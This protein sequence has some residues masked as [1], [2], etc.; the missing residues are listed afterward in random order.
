MGMAGARFVRADLHVHLVPDGSTSPNQPAAAYINAAVAQNIEV[1]GITDHN[2]ITF[3]R[4]ALNAAVGQP[5]LVL[6]G[7]EV[8]SRDGHLL[9]LFP[10][11]GLDEL[12]GFASPT[13]L[14]LGKPLADGSRR[15]S[16]TMLHLLNEVEA[17]HG[18][19]IIAHCDTGAGV[20]AE[21]KAG[22]LAELL[23]HPALAGVEFIDLGNLQSWFA[24]AD[25][26]P[27]RLAAWK[28]RQA[29][30]EL[31]ERG[32]ARVM[33]SDAHDASL[34]GKDG[35]RRPLT[36]LRV[37][38]RTYTA[39]RNALLYNPKS[40]VRLEASLPASYPHLTSATFEGGFL[41][42]VTIDLVQNLNCLIGGRGSGKSTAL[43]A[44]L[45]ALG[46]DLAADV[47]PDDP[48]RM[49]DRTIVR[50]VDAAGTERQAIRERGYAPTDADGY[51]VELKLADLSQGESGQVAL[52]YR[53]QRTQILAYLDSFCDLA[54]QLDAER[55]VLERLS[56]N[57]ADVQRTAFRAAD[58]KAAEAE[59]AKLDANIM[60]AEKGQLE[61]IAKWARR[62][63]GQ[64]ALIAQVRANLERLGS[65]R[66]TAAMP[67]LDAL[68][69]ETQADLDQ[70][71]IKDLRTPLDQAISELNLAL[72]SADGAHATSIKVAT[73][74]VTAVIAQ[75][76]LEYQRWESKRAKV[77]KDLED[78]GLSVQVGAIQ[79]MG[80]RLGALTKQLAEMEERRK[81]HAAALKARQGLLNDLRECRRLIY[82]RRRATLRK[83]TAM[84][85]DS[86]LDLKVDVSYVHEGV[87]RPWREWLQAR[88]GF[89]ADRLSRLGRTIRPWEFAEAVA[90]GDLSPI[91]KIKDTDGDGRP[92]FTSDD[93]ER[94]ADLSWEERFEIET[95]RLE[96]LPRVDVTE[97]SL[98][99]GFDHLSTG[100]Q[101]S[102]LLSLLLCA[103]RSDPLIIDQPE[104]HLDAPYIAN[105]VVRHLEA[106]KERRQV[107]IATH[108]A[109]LTVLGDAE[110]VVPL[111]SVN[112]N[113]EVRDAGAIDHPDT[114]RHVC[115]LL[116]GGASAYARRG[117]RYGFDVGPIPAGLTI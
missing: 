18:L 94:I 40:R 46:A 68:A 76:D 30:A 43:L 87:R 41:N 110:L 60:A 24:Y 58:Y 64:R 89:K 49:P 96:D 9:A 50:F 34:V 113:G 2:S 103:D 61:E 97:G 10:P 16:R 85:N 104:D 98:R 79:A 62:L 111:Y 1:L 32:L 19:G 117:Q 92:F 12:E 88:F 107:I 86:A 114:L 101:H 42:G 48:A 7:V 100:Q 75:W 13:N 95:M 21:I 63:A 8:G 51:P 67:R 36:R 55:D 69:V 26:E 83:V 90:K 115:Q 82:V 5:I 116:E 106:A 57:A 29:V 70:K 81:Q 109:N 108:N 74:K 23:S 99:R 45:A 20:H 15:S 47:D 39:V 52:D 102:V 56:D 11:D 3:V 80:T 38:D 54:S 72:A 59:R 73:A 78:K 31:R 27:A 105:A 22:E 4:D 93:L 77:Q 84:A 25:A 66:A 65:A 14:D 28:A 6:P 35:V 112:G 91:A 33:S 44:I 17:R 71:P 53:T 37:G